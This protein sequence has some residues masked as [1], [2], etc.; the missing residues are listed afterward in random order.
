M[1]FRP[2]E[3]ELLHGMPTKAEKELGWKRK[4]DFDT[5]VREMVEADLVGVRFSRAGRRMLRFA[6]RWGAFSF[7]YRRERRITTKLLRSASKSN[8]ANAT[9]QPVSSSLSIGNK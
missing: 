5:L 3:V 8:P 6:D 1:Y 7:C 4:I 2:A 9:S